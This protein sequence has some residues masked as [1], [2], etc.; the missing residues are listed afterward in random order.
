MGGSEVNE[1]PSAAATG[2]VPYTID[3]AFG[4]LIEIADKYMSLCDVMMTLPKRKEEL[5]AGDRFM[6]ALEALRD[7]LMK[8]KT[9]NDRISDPA[10]R[11][12]D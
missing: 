4:I 10:K 12:V 7:E 5:A 8:R 2:S 6:D 9:P 1:H 3:K 11:R